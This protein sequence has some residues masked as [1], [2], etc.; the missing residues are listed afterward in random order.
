MSVRAQLALGVV[1]IVIGPACED[2][3]RQG[4]DDG[5]AEAFEAGREAGREAAL[6]ESPS[7]PTGPTVV[8]EVCGADGVTVNGKHYRPGPTGCV[9]VYSDGTSQRY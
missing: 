1:M 5:Y 4:Y 9:R 8:S 3:Y 6:E 7:F 2:R